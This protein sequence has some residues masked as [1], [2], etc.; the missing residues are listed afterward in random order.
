[1]P[2]VSNFEKL[3]MEKVRQ[4][5]IKQEISLIIRQLKRK[6]G[7]FSPELESKIRDLSIEK[8]EDLGES[9]LDFNSLED[10]ISWLDN[11]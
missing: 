4:E 9:L 5:M 2:L 7:N 8:L 10:L 6:I 11:N 3:A 1:M